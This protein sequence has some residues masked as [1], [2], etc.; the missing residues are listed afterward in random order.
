MSATTT[1]TQDTWKNINSMVNTLAL[2]GAPKFETQTPVPFITDSLI[3]IQ[4][5]R[6]TALKLIEND[7]FIGHFVNGAEYFS[8]LFAHA[9]EC[10]FVSR[11]YFYL[12]KTAIPRPLVKVFSDGRQQRILDY[13]A[14]LNTNYPYFIY[15]AIKM[16]VAGRDETVSASAISQFS[17]ENAK[18]RDQR[19]AGSAT[20]AKKL[21]SDIVKGELKHPFPSNKDEIL[22]CFL[23]E[24]KWDSVIQDAFQ[25]WGLTAQKM[26]EC[27]F[28]VIAAYNKKQKIPNEFLRGD[29]YNAIRDD[30]LTILVE[31]DNTSETSWIDIYPF[32]MAAIDVFSKSEDILNWKFKPN[33][34][35]NDENL[36]KTE[37][38]CSMPFISNRMR[39]FIGQFAEKK[40]RFLLETY[41][42]HE[43]TTDR[44]EQLT[45][46]FNRVKDEDPIDS[47]IPKLMFSL[48][49]NVFK[50]SRLKESHV[51]FFA[52]IL[53][54]GF[55]SKSGVLYVYYNEQES[56]QF[57]DKFTTIQ[58]TFHL[59]SAY[60]HPSIYIK[61]SDGWKSF[62]Y[63][64]QTIVRGTLTDI[65]RVIQDAKVP[66]FAIYEI[67]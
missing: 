61:E 18:Y 10:L 58:S 26:F 4:I 63:I 16:T 15:Q 5:W 60:T 37:R 67:Q 7:V 17:L 45:R 34:V 47:L 29:A 8:D 50:S 28:D 38:L 66:V 52:D 65:V 1:T 23:Q 48:S 31:Y 13:M 21:M 22:L 56:A 9:V 20:D 64:G 35:V 39:F 59:V 46:F 33:Q 11:L 25:F 41:G 44:I 24:D 40:A 57:T 55:Y 42:L 14:A 6:N 54:T 49:D 3:A 2:H 62:F 12:T 51:I 27:A 19:Q 43:I 30:V 32:H 36:L 53:N